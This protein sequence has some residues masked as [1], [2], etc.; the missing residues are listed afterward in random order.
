MLKTWLGNPKTTI[1]ALVALGAVV[2]LIIGKISTD[3]A[4]VV[5]GVAGT[6]VGVTAKDANK[7]GDSK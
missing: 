5:L 3:V 7:S 4:V 1:G 6:W 2:A